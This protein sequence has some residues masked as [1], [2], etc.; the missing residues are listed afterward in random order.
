MKDLEER[1]RLTLVNPCGWNPSEERGLAL[2]CDN[3]CEH[4]YSMPAFTRNKSNLKFMK[5]VLS[6]A[7]NE[8]DTC[9]EPYQVGVFVDKDCCEYCGKPDSPYTYKG[10]PFCEEHYGD[11]DDMEGALLFSALRRAGTGGGKDSPVTSQSR[12]QCA[13]CDC[14]LTNKGAKARGTCYTCYKEME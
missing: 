2:F 8:C 6:E 3:G 9:G 11:A 7:P 1:L 12:E 4:Q 10:V 13:L 5:K 14:P